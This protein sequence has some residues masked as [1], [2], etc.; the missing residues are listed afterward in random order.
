ME[1]VGFGLDITKDKILTRGV[2][3]NKKT[4]MVQREFPNKLLN[5]KKCW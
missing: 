4:E 1:T 2:C 5:R 3:N